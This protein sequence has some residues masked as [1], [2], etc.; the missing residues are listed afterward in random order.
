MK[1]IVIGLGYFGSKLASDL[2]VMGHEVIGI[3]IHSERLEEL[4]DSVT[5]VLKMD[6]TGI[7]A[8]KTLPLHDCDAVIVAIGEDVGSSILTSAILKN[9][10]VKRIIAR[11]INQ[12]HQNILNQI[13]IEEVILPLEDS[14][15]H[16]AS[17]LQLR[18]AIGINELNNDYAI[19]EIVVPAKYAGH[20]LETINMTERFNLKLICVKYPPAE[21]V[22]TS[23]FKRG[24]K[25]D[26]ARDV[27]LPLGVR[28][29]LVVVGRITDIKRFSES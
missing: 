18:N 4:K 29:V 9:L 13:G 17:M 25:V 3:D 2:T 10:K 12:T 15:R 11:A 14:A 26:L 28:D 8:L 21:S 19:A 20:A 22:L 7:N 6:S 27:S 16:V 1:Y 24:Y 5:T 23:L